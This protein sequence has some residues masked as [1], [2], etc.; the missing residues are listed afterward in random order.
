[1]H[2]QRVQNNNY[3]PSFKAELTLKHALDVK[4]NPIL[5]D[6]FVKEFSEKVTKLG[7]STDSVKID[8]RPYSGTMRELYGDYVMDVEVVR[9]NEKH[10]KAAA[11]LLCPDIKEGLPK[12]L[13]GEYKWLTCW[14]KDKN[15]LEKR[16]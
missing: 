13:D 2:V 9:N 15:G 4:N 14:F 5:K 10:K 8:V 16:V 6:S 12:F 1:M 7:K 11:L 3:S